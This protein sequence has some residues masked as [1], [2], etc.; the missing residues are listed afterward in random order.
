M[1]IHACPICEREYVRAPKSLWKIVTPTDPAYGTGYCSKR[2]AETDMV[3]PAFRKA[4]VEKYEY[5]HEDTA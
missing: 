3:G 2:C 5:R 1:V 4:H